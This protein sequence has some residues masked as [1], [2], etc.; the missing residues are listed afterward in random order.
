MQEQLT[1]SSGKKHHKK[2]ILEITDFIYPISKLRAKKYKI[3]DHVNL[4]GF[5]PLKGALFIPMTN[6]YNYNTK[7]GIVVC[8]LKNG[9]HPNK[10]EIKILKKAGIQA[11]CFNLVPRAI[12]ASA[13]GFKVSATGIVK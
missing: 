8:G 1:R 7:Q 4:S 3:K 11:Y 9:I 12:L 5:N 2:K 6:I 13:A 10:N